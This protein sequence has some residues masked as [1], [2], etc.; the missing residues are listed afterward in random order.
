MVDVSSVSKSIK[1]SKFS[2]MSNDSGIVTQNSRADLKAKLN[3]LKYTGGPR[4]MRSFYLRIC[5][6][7]IEKWPF[8]GTH[9]LVYSDCWSF[10]MR[11]HYMQA[12]F[13]SP[14]LLHITRSTCIYKYILVLSNI[15]RKTKFLTRM[16]NVNSFSNL[17]INGLYSKNHENE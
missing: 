5:V 10:Y 2:S 17:A 1:S 15:R 8:S 9:P 14:Y 11:I 16:G 4:Y 13:W 7:A 12:Y 3:D 6:Y